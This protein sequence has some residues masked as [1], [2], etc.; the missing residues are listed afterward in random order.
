M[1]HNDRIT[2]AAELIQSARTRMTLTDIERLAS[3]AGVK[4]V[5]LFSAYASLRAR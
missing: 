2:L 4:V 5:D 1:S 3:I